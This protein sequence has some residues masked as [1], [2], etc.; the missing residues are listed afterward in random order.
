[1]IGKNSHILVVLILAGCVLLAGCTSSPPEKEIITP[2]P[3]PTP[4]AEPETPEETPAP[5]PVLERSIFDGPVTEPPADLE[6]SVSAQK[7]PVYNVITV[8]FNGGKGQQLLKSLQVRVTTADGV[9][10]E[11]PL[12]TNQGAE[13]EVPGTKGSDRVQV[14]AYYKNGEP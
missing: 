13:V 8:V 12:A 7:D 6:V 2:S 11:L 5:T 3:T 4:T 9:V 1:M 10:T 14:A